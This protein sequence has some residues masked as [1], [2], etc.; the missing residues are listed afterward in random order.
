LHDREDTQY[1]EFYPHIK[2]LLNPWMILVLGVLIWWMDYSE[3]KN[4]EK[5][6]AQLLA[7][8]DLIYGAALWL[9]VHWLHLFRPLIRLQDPLRESRKIV[10]YLHFEVSPFAFAA[11]QL[12]FYLMCIEVAILCRQW[13][14]VSNNTVA[15]LQNQDRPLQA[16]LKHLA[17]AFFQW[18]IASAALALA[19]LYLTVVY[20]RLI[21]KFHSME[22]IPSAVLTHVLWGIAW[23]FAS[24]PLKAAWDG[25]QE[26]RH[27]ELQDVF[28]TLKDGKDVNVANA[29]LT[30]LQQVHPVGLWPVVA[31]AIVAIG[32]F[33]GPVLK[34]VIDNL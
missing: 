13:R 4:P 14:R 20:W 9:L 10:S 1:R 26:A 29:R 18:Q 5:P 30:L 25:W 6:R 2:M 23:C 12:F 21:W 8:R 15:S 19:F 27:T 33:L 17:T 28:F 34:A 31:S 3:H 32:S 22:H 24:L 16:T 7:W 11:D